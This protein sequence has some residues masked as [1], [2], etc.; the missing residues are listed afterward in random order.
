MVRRIVSAAAGAPIVF[1]AI[2]FG[3]PW[4]FLLLAAVAVVAALEFFRMAPARIGRFLTFFG[5]AWVGLFILSARY[6]V[7][8]GTPLLIT[9]SVLI[10]L[11]WLV[12]G[13]GQGSG[14]RGRFQPPAPN[15][16]PL[17]PALRWAW[18]LAGI[19]YVGW[20]LGHFVWLRD[21]SNGRE[22]VI[23][24]V[25]STFAADTT[26][27]FV[28]RAW[29]RCPLAPAIS[30]GKTWEGAV[31][32]FMAATLAALALSV[33]LGLQAGYG[34]VLVVGGLIGVFGQLGDLAESLLKRSAGV[35]DAGAVVPGHGGILDRLDS[36]LFGVVV[37]Y[38]YLT[39]TVV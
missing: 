21:M 18:T 38:Y 17:A 1:A 27:F 14:V 23:L 12:L 33:A 20:L 4:Y 30:P 35:K 32:G 31:S 22:W 2:S 19:F 36:V 13:G 26:A 6:P 3:E 25:F 5:V 7:P 28:G 39:W 11:F 34:H 24:A 16:Q 29:G 37:V 9:S 10:P 8:G 15:P